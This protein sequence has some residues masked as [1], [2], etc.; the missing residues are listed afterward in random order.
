MHIDG[1]RRDVDVP[2]QDLHHARLNALLQQPRCVAM[3]QT[4][5]TDRTLRFAV[6]SQG[7]WESEVALSPA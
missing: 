5:G 3:A 4:V 1:R 7:W 6:P 2:E